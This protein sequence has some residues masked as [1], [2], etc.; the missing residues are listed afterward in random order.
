MPIFWTTL[1]FLCLCIMLGYHQHW[2]SQR[3]ATEYSAKSTWRINEWNTKGF[4]CKVYACTF[5]VWYSFLW[6]AGFRAEPQNLPFS[7]EFC[8]ISQKLRNDR[9]LVLSLAWWRNFIIIR[10]AIAILSVRPS[11]R[12]SHRWISQKWCKL[13][14]PNLHH[15]LH[16][17]L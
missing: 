13:R 7:A 9:R 17:R 6:V 11:V 5:L 16:G 12:L 1:Y 4:A 14:S 10:L 8:R 2:K 15:R 3:L